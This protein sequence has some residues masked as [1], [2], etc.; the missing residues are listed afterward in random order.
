MNIT[1][2]FLLATFAFCTTAFGQLQWQARTLTFNPGPSDEKIVAEYNFENVGK[3]PIKIK[4]VRTSCGCTTATLEKE[5][6][7]PGEKGKITAS[8][9]IETR[10]GPQQ[11]EIYVA[12]TDRKEPE[13]L[14]TLKINIPVVLELDTI[15]LDWQKG[16]ELKPKIVNVK[17][18]DKYP[19]HELEVTSTSP[20]MTAEVR[21]V[22]GTRNFQIV[23]T[24]K[25]TAETLKAGLEIKPDFPKEPAK[26]FHVYTRVDH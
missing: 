3:T 8:F 19:I 10:T 17:V 2:Y 18:S 9:E 15:F 1:R 16:E 26:Y 6:Y 23:V 25:P 20:N 11:K 14:L 22:E 5:I 24:P 4:Q 12:T 21:R 7:A 13:L